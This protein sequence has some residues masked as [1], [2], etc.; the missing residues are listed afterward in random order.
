MPAPASSTRDKPGHDEPILRPVAMSTGFRALVVAL[1][2]FL[3]AP[4]FVVLL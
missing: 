1:F 2:C 4:L 3:L